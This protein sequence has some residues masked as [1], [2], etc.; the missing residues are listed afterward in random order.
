MD[1]IGASGCCKNRGRVAGVAAHE[2]TL[3]Y[4]LAD[5]KRLS[6]SRQLLRVALSNRLWIDTD[7]D[8][9]RLRGR[10]CILQ[11]GCRVGVVWHGSGSC[12]C[13]TT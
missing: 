9:G 10:G 3:D 1:G 2:S 13:D 12:V 8:K 11:S 6:G 5:S 7:I 4:V